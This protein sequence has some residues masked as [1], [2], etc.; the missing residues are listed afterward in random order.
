[1]DHLSDQ[2]LRQLG[3]PGR[4][5]C[6][7]WIDHLS[8]CSRCRGRA[9]DLAL[10]RELTEAAEAAPAD[11]VDRRRRPIAAAASA[12]P[13]SRTEQPACTPRPA[14]SYRRWLA[15]A[16]VAVLALGLGWLG[17]PRGEGPPDRRWREPS[18]IGQEVVRLVPPDGA[19]LPAGSIEF[20]WQPVEHARDHRLHVLDPRGD[21]V[22]EAG[23]E[24]SG[25][26]V[27]T[28]AAALSPGAY[29]WYVTTHLDDGTEV[30]SSSGSFVIVDR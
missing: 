13:R 1:M 28:A 15:A 7:R 16:A 9:A 17:W 23:S 5:E 24:R 25:V 27:D 2:Q 6:A 20:R 29:F 10:A 18:L 11:R 4:G 3:E 19:R 26:T 21:V 12:S 30:L 14:R 8:R 22:H